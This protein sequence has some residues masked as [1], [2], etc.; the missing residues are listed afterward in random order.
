MVVSAQQTE[1]GA[2][3]VRFESRFHIWG[4]AVLQF[5]AY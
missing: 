3:Q 1:P 4:L 2:E 5:P